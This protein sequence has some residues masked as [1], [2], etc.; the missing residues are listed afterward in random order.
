MSNS[1]THIE[2]TFKVVRDSCEI[3]SWYAVTPEQERAWKL[4]LAGQDTAPSD[5]AIDAW[6]DKN[7]AK[8]DRADGPAILMKFSD[9]S[10]IEEWWANGNLHRIGAP[11]LVEINAN[12]SRREQWYTNDKL[13]RANGPA[14]VVR[15]RD[16]T[17]LF[18][19]WYHDGLFEKSRGLAPHGL[20]K[21]P[22]SPAP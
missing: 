16:G 17:I 22:S 3:T 13:D 11:A 10:R 12:G 14:I 9:G 5:E 7:E 18:E 4:W 1:E 20:G 15:D 2:I 21:P 8:L 19:A 6:L